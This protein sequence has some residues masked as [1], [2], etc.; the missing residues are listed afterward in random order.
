VVKIAPD[1]ES[2]QIDALAEAL[3]THDIDAVAATNTTSSRVGVEGM[4][5]AE[6][7]GGLSGE[8]LFE[9][10]TRV[11]SRLHERLEGAVP[12]IGVGGIARGEDAAAKVR[13]G[14]SLVQIYTG[15]IYRGPHLIS[16]AVRAIAALDRQPSQPAE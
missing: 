1:M 2:A 7:A 11:L 12:I 9:H 16:E 4:P 13:A 5:C 3:K 8:P 14:A 10:A 6:E 15:F